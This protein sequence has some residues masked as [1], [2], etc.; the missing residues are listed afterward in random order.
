MDK[1]KHSQAVDIPKYDFKGY[2]ND[3]F[4][5]RRVYGTFNFLLV[6]L[7]LVLEMLNRTGQD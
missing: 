2:K 1:L 7:L 6:T 3:V 5:A 4:P